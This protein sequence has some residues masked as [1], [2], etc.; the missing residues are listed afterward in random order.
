M[1]VPGW[2]QSVPVLE[3]DGL[4]LREI[5]TGDASSLLELL[6]TKDVTQFMSPLPPTRGSFGQFVEW[7]H[8]QRAAGQCICFVVLPPGVS[9]PAGVLQLRS[10]APGL[11]AAEWGSALGA[12]YWGPGLFELSA[13]LVPD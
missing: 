12:A 11:L 10:A 2:R 9:E 4:T 5:R 6:A 13:R 7:P 8:Q 1:P 3:H